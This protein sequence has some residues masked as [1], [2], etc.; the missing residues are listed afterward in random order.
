MLVGIVPSVIEALVFEI[1]VPLV[2]VLE[3]WPLVAVL[4]NVPLVENVLLLVLLLSPH[5]CTHE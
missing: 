3:N 2:E 5:S 1:P 4:E